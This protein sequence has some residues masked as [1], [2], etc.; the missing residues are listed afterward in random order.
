MSS[1]LPPIG[2]VLPE[3]ALALAAIVLLL[4]GAFKGER[5]ANL[6][7]GLAIAVLAAVLLLVLLKPNVP[8][9]A[10]NGSLV[11]D[12]FSRFMKVLAL[13][14]A[15]VSLIMSVDWLNARVRTSSN[16]RCWWSSP[17]SA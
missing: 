14:G 1:F 4:I 15:T 13:L 7:T 5:S 2:A 12:P 9:T 6:V 3:L 11:I 17:P 16:M 8:V 10:F